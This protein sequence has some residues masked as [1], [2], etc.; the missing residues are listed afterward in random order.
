MGN[1][2]GGYLGV[3]NKNKITTTKDFKAGE[4][5]IYNSEKTG[6][7]FG[8]PKL[9]NSNYDAR[10]RPWYKKT[11]NNKRPQWSDIFTYS[12]GSDIAISATRPVYNNSIFKGVLAVSLS[13]EQISEF[14]H[15]E[16]KVGKTGQTFILERNGLLVASSIKEKI[17]YKKDSKIERLNASNSSSPLINKSVEFLQKEF[18]NL[19]NIKNTHQ[20]EFEI[21]GKPQYLQVTPY[22]DDYGLD[23]LIVVVI[24]EADF[25]EEIHQNQQNTILLC[26]LPLITSIVICIITARRI[27]QPISR[28]NEAVK[29]ITE[30]N[31][32]GTESVK[33]S[34]IDEVGELATSFNSMSHELHESFDYLEEKN[35]EL[36][37]L[38]KL[39]DEFLAN[40][41]HELRTPLNGMIGIAES[42]IDGATG[43][44]TPL[45]QKNLSMIAGSG[46]RLLELVNDILD[47]AKLKN[48]GLELQ[49][50]PVG[51]YSLVDVVLT[52]SQSLVGDKNLKLINSVPDNL[53]LAHADEHRLEQI[54]FNIIGNSIKFTESGKVEVSAKE[55]Q[56]KLTITISD[57]GIGIPPE[58][59]E[60][61]FE[62]F[63]Q[64]DGSTA[65]EYGGT[66]LGLAVTKQL[67][68]LHGGQIWVE[69]EVGKGS[70]FSFTLP[71][72]TN[73]QQQKSKNQLDNQ[74]IQESN[75]SGTKSKTSQIIAQQKTESNNIGSVPKEN[76]EES[77]ENIS[78]NSKYHILIVDDEPVNLQVLNNHLSLHEYRVTQALS[79]KEA[80]NKVETADNI[81]LV[82]LDI[83]MPKMSGYKVCAK[84]REKYPANQLPIVLLTAKNQ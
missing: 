52:F 14:L 3:D 41:S 22:S 43:E 58:K 24:P 53:P 56:D 67:V 74:N 66:G 71:I 19:S 75:L 82:L 78:N 34:R 30:G 61:I 46:H 64:A 5:L 37:R 57:T 55:D 12:D 6:R 17:Y 16:L 84:L 27:S 81:D 9:S 79:G 32:E 77:E 83:M 54:L 38:D 4:L 49:Q 25:M 13:L 51:I 59:H 69:S 31:W 42:V 44:I 35:E 23:W 33:G 15:Y 68:E 63:E 1:E 65:R 48:Q 28:L 18:G 36:E 10:L 2:E 72:V 11:K 39:K 26:L 7:R 29:R 73:N 45:Q 50:K 47:F 20:L 80:L 76:T 60:K 70:N 62:S 21:K 40:T 8:I